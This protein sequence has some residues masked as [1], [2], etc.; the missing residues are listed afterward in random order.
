MDCV[1]LGLPQGAAAL[2]RAGHRLLAAGLERPPGV[3]GLRL[4]PTCPV[5][6]RPPMT[7]PGVRRLLVTAGAPLLV[8]YLWGRLLPGELLGAFPQGAIGYHP[9][10]LP[11]HRGPDP[12]FWTLWSR[13]DV[14]GVSVMRLD[15]GVDTGHVLAQQAIDTP[16]RA[17]GGELADLLD[18]LGLELLLGV[19]ARW[20]REGPLDGWPQDESRATAAPSPDDELLEIRWG[21]PAERIARLVRAAAPHPGAFTAVELG[22]SPRTLVVL[23]ARVSSLAVGGALEPGDAVLIDEGVVVWTGAGGLVLDEVLLDDGTPRR[24]PAEIAALFEG[25]S[26][27]RRAPA[28]AGRG[29]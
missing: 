7:D 6:V 19:V 1:Y 9:S 10:L 26:D 23:A 15:A 16:P 21:W 22:G 8:C 14:A 18:P 24:G 13:D 17:T 29:A 2:A 25:I 5:L 20:G 11:R 27:L 28:G 12:Y 3:T 4:G